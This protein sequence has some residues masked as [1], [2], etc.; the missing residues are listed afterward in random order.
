MGCEILSDSDPHASDHFPV[1]AVL[2]SN[3]PQAPELGVEHVYDYSGAEALELLWEAAAN[4][5]WVLDETDYANIKRRQSDDPEC[6]IAK[7]LLRE[8][9]VIQYET[10]KAKHPGHRSHFFAEAYVAL[11]TEL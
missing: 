8:Y 9:E 3:A 1:L 2:Q 5:V 7:Q 10:A 6:N 4:E 11:K